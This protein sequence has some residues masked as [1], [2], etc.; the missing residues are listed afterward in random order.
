MNTKNYFTIMCNCGCGN[1]YCF[2]NDFDVIWIEA[3]NSCFSS[4]QEAIGSKYLEK[5]KHI[6]RILK[7]KNIYLNE[8]CLNEEELKEFLKH[9]EKLISTLPDE[10]TQDVLEAKQDAKRATLNISCIEYSASQK[11]MLWDVDT[12][13]FSLSLKSKL[14]IKDV[15]TNKE[16][17]QYDTTIT[18]KECV[19]FIRKARK[20]LDKMLQL[21]KKS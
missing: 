20:Y 21:K 10:D 14:T 5:V 8:I 18:K 19:I 1:G 12:L 6:Q 3:L 2:K 9:L 15:L 17:R 4:K 11:K 7:G 16:Y 13:T